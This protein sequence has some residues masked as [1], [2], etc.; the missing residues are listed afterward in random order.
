MW[1]PRE[2][3]PAAS[4][5]AQTV[6]AGIMF[7]ILIPVNLAFVPENARTVILV[8]PFLAAL[9]CLA[10]GFAWVLSVANVFFR[11]VEHLLAVIFLPWFFL[12]PVLYGLEQFRGADCAPHADLPAS[13]RESGDAVRRRASA[14]SRCRRWFRGRRCSSTSSSSARSRRCFGLWVVQRYEDRVAIEL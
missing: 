4:V 14:R 6:V 2:L 7:A 13:L 12:T 1:F 3:I 10:L 5:L 8:I 11:D 9:L